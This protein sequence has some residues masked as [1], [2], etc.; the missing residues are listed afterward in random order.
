[1]I[2]AHTQFSI[3]SEYNCIMMVDGL[4]T[5][6]TGSK[7]SKL[8]GTAMYVNNLKVKSCQTYNNKRDIRPFQR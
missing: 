5:G 4:E 2:Y 7:M 8:E 6:D 1:M 3:A